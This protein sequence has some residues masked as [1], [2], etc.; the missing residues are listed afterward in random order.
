[1]KRNFKFEEHRKRLPDTFKQFY[2]H[3]ES[4]TYKSHLNYDH[5]QQIIKDSLPDD[6]NDRTPY[7]WED[8]GSVDT[9]AGTMD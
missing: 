1:M 7:D 8:R 5:L 3:L 2:E 4:L 9:V 6:I